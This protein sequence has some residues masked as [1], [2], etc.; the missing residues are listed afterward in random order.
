MPDRQAAALGDAGGVRRL[1]FPA[2]STSGT[3]GKLVSIPRA[4]AQRRRH[5]ERKDLLI[6]SIFS[7]RR[8]QI[9][10]TNRPAAESQYFNRHK[11]TD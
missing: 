11:V 1:L 2:P 10:R 3:S 8:C 7:F 6:A 5:P 4:G 9:G